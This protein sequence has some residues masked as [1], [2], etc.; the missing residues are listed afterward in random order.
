MEEPTNRASI[1]SSLERE[2]ELLVAHQLDLLAQI[3]AQLRSVHHAMRR[4]ERMR[5]APKRVGAELS[6][7]ERRTMLVGLSAE[8]AEL[9]KH[10][11]EEHE[12][13]A[14]MQTTIRRMQERV[15]KLKHAAL[16]IDTSPEP[17]DAGSVD[18]R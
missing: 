14:L 18:T 17:E 8:I 2:A 4:I 11:A 6:N 10:L 12:G 16:G 9:D 15:A 13:C 7:G 5:G 1:I 3:E